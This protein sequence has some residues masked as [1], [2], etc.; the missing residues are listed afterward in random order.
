MKEKQKY[1]L[2]SQDKVLIQRDEGEKEIGGIAMA[3]SILQKIPKGIVI[4][5]GRGMKKG[6][7]MIVK[8]GDHVLHNPHAGRGTDITVDGK[9]CIIMQEGEILLVFDKKEKYGFRLLRNEI[10][11]V[12]DEEEKEF[13]KGILKPHEQL[14]VSR[15]GTVV[16]VGDMSEEPTPLHRGQKIHYYANTGSGPIEGRIL[17]LD[18]KKFYIVMK[19]MHILGVYE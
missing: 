1:F 12:P 3:P 15:T 19:V 4:A 13:A 9:Q 18:P 7:K 11:I 14:T 2:P 16:E 5:V 17:G 8:P 6:D 10:L